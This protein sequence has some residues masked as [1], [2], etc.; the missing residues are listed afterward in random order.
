MRHGC[1]RRE[2]TR[3]R[4]LRESRETNARHLPSLLVG[5]G[6]NPRA[7][8][9]GNSRGALTPI[10]AYLSIR[11][12][13]GGR[14]RPRECAVLPPLQ[15]RSVHLPLCPRGAAARGG[16][17]GS[18]QRGPSGKMGAAFRPRHHPPQDGTPT[19]AHHVFFLC[20]GSEPPGLA[21]CS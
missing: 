21:G 10:T 16:L 14:Q 20:S 17:G 11:L 19:L 8:I 3:Q 13:A 2:Q 4:P 15:E 18:D 6:M 7:P 1:L 5:R 9:A 12:T